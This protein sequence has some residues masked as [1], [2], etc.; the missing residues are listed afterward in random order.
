MRFVLIALVGAVATGLPEARADI[1]GDR[2]T[3]KRWSVSM[4]APS[5]WT[6]NEQ[7][8]YPNILL[9]MTPREVGVRM[10][11]SA[12]VQ[13]TRRDAQTYALET[14]KVL[15]TLGFTVRSP[16]RHIT[17]AYYVDFDNCGEETDCKGK[18][19]LRQAFLVVGNVGY[20]LTLSAPTSRSR[21]FYLRAWDAALRTMR[22][23]ASRAAPATPAE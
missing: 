5:N 23:T 16:Q 21:G 17:G 13:T 10:L 6:L 4:R 12:E 1:D 18:V 15:E 11:L 2:Y 19:F 22:V 3:S 9:W 7:T 8:S 20:A 14:S